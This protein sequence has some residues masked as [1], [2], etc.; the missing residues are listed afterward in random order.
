MQ[1]YKNQRM[2][3]TFYSLLPMGKSYSI[4]YL[5]EA[6]LCVG[7]VVYEQANSPDQEKIIATR[8]TEPLFL[9]FI[10]LLKVKHILL[11]LT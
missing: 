2:C 4:H 8:E 11:I 6:W 1:I 3:F 9:W 7:A 5:S 10:G